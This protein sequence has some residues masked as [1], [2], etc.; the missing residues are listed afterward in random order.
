MKKHMIV[1][2]ATC[3]IG[4]VACQAGYTWKWDPAPTN[5]DIKNQIADSMNK[6]RDSYNK[7]HSS[8][9]T[10]QIAVKYSST[11]KTAHSSPNS[12]RI[13]FGKSRSHATAMHETTHA[14]GAG[15]NKFQG[16]CDLTKKKWKGTKANDLYATW[17]TDQKMNCDKMHFWKYGMGGGWDNGDRH[18]QLFY[19]IRQDAGL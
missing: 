16:K 11:V 15:G 14:Y 6:T 5:T 17:H 3:V 7:H 9:W 4:S 12:G 13:T 8:E 18:V 19:Q 2:L 10:K 1:V